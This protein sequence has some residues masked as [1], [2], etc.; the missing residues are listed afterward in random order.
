[1]NVAE[2]IKRCGELARARASG[3]APESTASMRAGVC[4]PHLGD[5][6]RERVPCR[7]CGGSVELK[8]LS[9]S[10]HG[11]CTVS[12]PVDG[13]QCCATCPDRPR[14]TIPEKKFQKISKTNLLYYV[15]PVKGTGGWQRCLDKIAPFL[16]LFTGKIVFCVS[17]D[18][19]NGRSRPHDAALGPRIGNST[20]STSEVE[21]HVLERSSGLKSRISF[22]EVANDPHL[23]ESAHHNLLFSQ[24]LSL[25]PTEATLYAHAKGVTRPAASTAHRWYDVLIEV[26][27][28]HMPVALTQL[29]RFPVTGAFKKTGRG[30]GRGETKSNWHYSGS[31]A[32]YRNDKLFARNWR[33]IDR[34]WAA[35]E[36]YPST[37]FSRRE[38]GCV[39]HEGSVKSMNLYSPDYFRLNVEPELAMFRVNC[40]KL[41]HL[42]V[43]AG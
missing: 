31:F 16:H 28:E 12:R 9:C 20:D 26:L 25:D 32:L 30:F 13:I 29:E 35:I 27:V 19:V 6:T 2:K 17:Q 23:W 42:P 18:P 43:R 39:L 14:V 8:V 38:A 5:D 24:V 36:S 21:K 34:F 1:M 41:I 33:K 22:L 15:Y 10:L 11:K 37:H 4:C 7:S 3:F 40:I